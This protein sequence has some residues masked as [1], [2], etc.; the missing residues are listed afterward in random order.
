CALLLIPAV[1][2]AQTSTQST[3]TVQQSYMNATLAQVTCKANYLTGYIGD[4]ISVIP[5]I[6]STAISADSSKITTDLQTV[7]SDANNGNKTQFKTDIPTLRADFKSGRLDLNHAV[8]A[9]APTKDERSQLRTDMRSLETVEQSCMFAAEQQSAQA[10]VVSFQFGIQQEQNRSHKLYLRGFDTTQLNQT[11]SQAQTN[12]GNF[13]ASISSAINS[14][15]LKA[16]LQSYC[17]YDGC[18]SGTNFHF[19]AQSALNAEQAALTAIK[20]NQNSGQYS[21]QISQVQTDLTNAQ[22]TLSAVGTGQYQGT[23][24]TDVWNN[25]HNA[26]GIINQI[27]HGLNGH[28]TSSGSGT[29]SSNSGT[30]TSE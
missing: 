5:T 18:K 29:S 2:F 28:G 27:W 1:A 20:A 15:Q 16:A 23:Q 3:T 24:S 8:K 26:Q 6:N 14:T 12:L 30:T 25:L 19:A 21:T 22:N 17:Q 7:T 9:S 11:I 10:K 13:V 4:A